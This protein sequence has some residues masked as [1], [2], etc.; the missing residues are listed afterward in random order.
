MGAEQGYENITIHF[1]TLHGPNSISVPDHTTMLWLNNRGITNIKLDGMEQLPGLQRLH[2]EDNQIE[3]IDLTPLS[4]CPELR[5]LILTSNN[6][7]EIDLSPLSSLKNLQLVEIAA[8][9]LETIDTAPLKQCTQ[10][11][12]IILAKNKLTAIDLASIG[13]CRS[14]SLG[15]NHIRDIDLSELSEESKISYLSLESNQLK[16]FDL[17]SLPTKHLRTLNLS[18]NNLTKFDTSRVAS[19]IADLD[20]SNNMIASFDFSPLSIAGQLNFLSLAGNPLDEID[21]TPLFY[22]MTESEVMLVQGRISMGKSD[23]YSSRNFKIGVEEVR[24]TFDNNRTQIWP[25][26]KT[27]IIIAEEFRN[28]IESK[29]GSRERG[30]DGIDSVVWQNGAELGRKYIT[31]K[32]WNYFKE[33]ARNLPLHVIYCYLGMIEIRGFG[34]SL[35]EILDSVEEDYDYDEGYRFLYSRIVEVLENELAESRRTH[36]FDIDRMTETEAA[37]LIPRIAELRRQEIQDLELDPPDAKDTIH[38]GPLGDTYYGS[39]ILQELGFG[40][41][42]SEADFERIIRAFKELNIELKWPK[43]NRR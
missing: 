42:V 2:L 20:L 37:R 14:I 5:W 38:L 43:A 28:D 35:I 34:I 16:S 22:L 24:I 25:D 41:R 32:G 15:H 8:N 23:G 7:K 19:G 30:L 21:L 10:L 6:L 18:G 31:E 40:W 36:G 12:S 33:T 26:A 1:E 9:Q 27:R 17:G 3:E 13:H 29:S 4:K 39:I 11:S